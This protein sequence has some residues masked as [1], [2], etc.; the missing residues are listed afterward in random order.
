MWA[1]LALYIWQRR[2]FCSRELVNFVLI[3]SHSFPS[4]RFISNPMYFVPCHPVSQMYLSLIKV[5]TPL[6]NWKSHFR[7][8]NF[9]GS[10]SGFISVSWCYFRLHPCSHVQVLH[11]SKL[12][13]WEQLA[14]FLD[15][16]TFK[17]QWKKRLSFTATNTVHLLLWNSTNKSCHLSFWPAQML[18]QNSMHTPGHLKVTNLLLLISEARKCKINNQ[19]DKQSHYLGRA[20]FLI[21]TQS[22]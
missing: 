15:T 9:K 16:W 18:Q 22:S 13:C 3:P 14:F 11:C 8:K 20:L 21:Q 10:K 7:K 19:E 5:K 2:T 4:I 17:T 12:N 1:I 6:L